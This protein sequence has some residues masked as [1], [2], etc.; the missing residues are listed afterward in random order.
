MPNSQLIL[1]YFQVVAHAGLLYGVF[2]FTA[3]EF[4]LVFFVYFLTGCL[5][6]SIGFHRMLS[7]NSLKCNRFWVVVCSILG[8]W[9]L[10]GSPI[11]W[12]NTHRAH[13]RY[14][15]TPR[16]P[17]SPGVLGYFTV[18][19][20]SMFH[21][22]TTLRYVRHMRKDAF[23]VFLHRNYFRLHMA[24]FAALMLIGGFHLAALVY[25][26]PAAILWN[27]GSL[28][29]TLCHSSLGY[30]NHDIKDS[31]KNN[32]ILGWLMW[33]EGFHNNHHAHPL[34]ARYG[35]KWYELDISWLIMRMIGK[36]HVD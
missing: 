16:D 30:R 26:A 1:F 29:N 12:V 25:L 15:D 9:G 33:G 24:V 5:G 21:S 23:Q 35:I 2:N 34:R 7:H 6:M 14:V 4:L 19:W 10:V 22:S 13:H 17:H 18:Q 32:L 8:S 27:A 28:V 36:R 11:A 31:S 3:W 20:F